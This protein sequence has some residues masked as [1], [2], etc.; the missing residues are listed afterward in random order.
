MKGRAGT[1]QTHGKRDC[2]RR[3]SL[4]GISP[5]FQVNFFFNMQFIFRTSLEVWW[6]RL[7]APNAGGPGLDP[8]SGNKIPHAA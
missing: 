5:F 6:L 3:S 8:W 7:C 2:C 1:T 4:W